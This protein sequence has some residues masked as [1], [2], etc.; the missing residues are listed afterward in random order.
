MSAEP[1][2]PFRFTRESRIRIDVD[3]YV[4]HEGER[5]ERDRLA[6]T[7][8]SW[9]D[10]DDASERYVMRNAIDWCYVTVDDAPLVVRHVWVR[11][12]RV[13]VELSDDAREVLSLDGLHLDPNGVVYGYAR[14]GTLLARFSRSAAFV[15]LEHARYRDDGTPVL[16]VGDREVTFTMLDAATRPAPRFAR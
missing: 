16:R 1:T 15:L 4:W 8:A 5:I 3:G 10:Y 14:G 6:R 13:D 9:V 7:L 2:P 12:D 11:D